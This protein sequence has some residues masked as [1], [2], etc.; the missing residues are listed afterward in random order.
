MNSSD[1][2]LVLRIRRDL[3]DSYDEEFELELEDHNVDALDSS[4]VDV[5]SEKVHLQRLNQF[6]NQRKIKE[7]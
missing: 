7:I 5:G 6:R 4:T 2:D 3:A 1:D